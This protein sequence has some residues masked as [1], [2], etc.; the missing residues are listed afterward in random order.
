VS[1]QWQWTAITGMLLLAGAMRLLALGQVPPGLAHD[2]VNNWLIAKDILSGHHAIYFTAAYGHEPLY[3]YVQAATVHLFGSHWLGLRWPSFAFGLLGI[4]ATYSLVRHLFDTRIALLTLLGMAVSLWPLFYARVAYRAITLPFVASLA[5]YFF[6]RQCDSVASDGKRVLDWLLAGLFL[7]LSLYTYMAA[8]ILP[9]IFAAVVVYT[10]LVRPRTSIPWTRA[11]LVFSVAALTSAP[12]L[13]WL[14][15]HPGAEYRITEVR[16]PLD[17]LLA[18]DPSLMWHNLI[19]NL[20]FFTF[21]GDP[22]ARYN[23]PG[24]PVFGTPILGALFLGGILIALGRWREPRYGFL[25]IWLIGSLA[26]SVVTSEAPSSIRNILGLVTTF[27]F[28]A[29]SIV[30]ISR[31]TRSGISKLGF[32]VGSRLSLIGHLI[33]VVLVFVPSCLLTARDYF[34]RWPQLE[35]VRYVHQTALTAIAHQLDQLPPGATVAVAGWSAHTL[36]GPT[37]DLAARRDV[38]EVRLFDLH[39]DRTLVVPTGP[40]SRLFVPKRIPFDEDL[41]ERLLAWGPEI[42]TDHPLFISYRLS[43]RTALHLALQNLNHDAVLPEGKRV[44]LPVSFAGR[45]TLLGY[46]WIERGD[47]GL[48]TLLTYWKV[49]DPS[50]TQLRSFVHLLEGGRPVAQDDKLGSP[51]QGWARGDLIVQKHLLSLPSDLSGGLYV[52]ELGLYDAATGAR[53][54]VNAADRIFLSP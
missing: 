38:S 15:A 5:A 2:E 4:A 35:A 48:L 40:D 46:E 9:F 34:F 3:Q 21:A 32:K 17:R 50:P 45:L 7:G 23:I 31:W 10:K 27:V 53:L 22:L 29:L 42:A 52:L 20:K 36:D 6:V 28:P 11:L 49:E 33:F 44:M 8:R 47:G 30:E 19:A 26:P 43:D 1:K 14:V 39:E 37:L 13:L 18:G 12:L 25:L 54:S 24:R 51:P 16:M 41:R